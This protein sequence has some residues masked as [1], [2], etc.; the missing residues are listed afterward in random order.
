[1]QAIW[2]QQLLPMALN[3]CPKSKKSSNL[4]TLLAKIKIVF[5]ISVSCL[6]AA[7]SNF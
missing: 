3:A 7:S 5:K 6:E 4:V 2:V 1:M